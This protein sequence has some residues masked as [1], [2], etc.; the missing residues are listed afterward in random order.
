MDSVRLPGFE[1][2]TALV[3]GGA[4][5]IGRAIGGALAQQGANE[6]LAD[7]TQPVTDELSSGSRPGCAGG[8]HR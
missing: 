1:G 5:G 8:R 4:R 7:V 2:W 3:P 6:V